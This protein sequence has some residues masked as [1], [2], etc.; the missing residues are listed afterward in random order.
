MQAQKVLLSNAS[1]LPQLKRSELIECANNAALTLSPN[2]ELHA[3]EFVSN[4]KNSQKCIMFVARAASFFA[5]VSV[6]ID[7]IVQI[8]FDT[9]QIE[10]GFGLS[11]FNK[12]NIS[13]SLVLSGTVS[14]TH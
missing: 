4:S 2:L 10:L 7:N 9:T 11:V 3:E 6:A 13:G 14:Y 5:N 12:L 8:I 1:D